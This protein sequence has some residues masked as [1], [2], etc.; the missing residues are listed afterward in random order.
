MDWEPKTSDFKPDEQTLL[1]VVQ[2]VSTPT[3]PWI[4]ACLAGACPKPAAKTFP[5]MTS[6]TSFGLRLIDYMAP[7]T[8]NPPNWVA[9]KLESFPKNEPIAVLLAA[10]IYTELI[11]IL[12]SYLQLYRFNNG[13]WLLINQNMNIILKTSCSTKII[14]LYKLIIEYHKYKEHKNKLSKNRKTR[15]WR[16]SML[17]YSS[18]DLQIKK[19]RIQSHPA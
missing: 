16:T 1:M 7:F 3:P 15:N 6:S 8:A 19:Q 12:N 14:A 4:E 18:K 2:G 10:T 11:F 9:E 17:L 13:L 5:K